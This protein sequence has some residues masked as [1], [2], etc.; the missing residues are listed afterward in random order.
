MF[1]RG[2]RMQQP[3]IT[4]VTDAKF[5]WGESAC[6][7]DALARLYCV[8]CEFRELRWVDSTTP[9]K[10][11]RLALPS[12]P[13]ALYLTATAG[14]V[15]VQLDDGL[16]AVDVSTSEIKRAIENPPG[17]PR[18]NDGVADPSGAIVTG[19][20]LFGTNLPPGKYWRYRKRAGWEEIHAGKGNTNG[21][22]FS[23]DGRY[24]YIADS[25]AGLIYRFDYGPDREPAGQRLF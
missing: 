14:R 11:H 16:Y 10:M 1:A 6:W 21:P 13:T 25:S 15:L 18:F 5:A 9:D 12:L 2:K 19:T 20:L 4:T 17:E 22:C 23:P 8:D 7:D 24:L 3:T